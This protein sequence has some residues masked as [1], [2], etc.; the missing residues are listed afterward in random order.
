[1][2]N[3]K[4]KTPLTIDSMYNSMGGVPNYGEQI[5]IQRTLRFYVSSS[6]FSPGGSIWNSLVRQRFFDVS[7]REKLWTA[8]VA[9]YVDQGPIS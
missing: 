6:G 5:E 9:F 3:Q 8:L 2:A 7:S 4:L 1:M